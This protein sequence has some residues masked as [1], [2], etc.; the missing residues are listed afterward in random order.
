MFL[1]VCFEWDGLRFSYDPVKNFVKSAT[2]REKQMAELKEIFKPVDEA[3]AKAEVSIYDSITIA[4]IKGDWTIL[5]PGGNDLVS[6]K[7]I[8]KDGAGVNPVDILALTDSIRKNGTGPIGRCF[9]PRHRINYY[10]DGIIVL[11]LL[12]CF[13][14]NELQFS[15]DNFPEMFVKDK[16]KR[17]QQMDSLRIVF[18]DLMNKN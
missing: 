16:G 5:D 18:K 2:V 9:F 11:Y 17:M 1:L 12:V 4:K 10:K 14:C 8:W 13:E 3:P 7:S 15:N 6:E